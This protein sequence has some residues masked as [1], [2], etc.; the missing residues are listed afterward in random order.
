MGIILE[1]L[2]WR[3]TLPE[4]KERLISL[5]TCGRI[6][7]KIILISLLERISIPQLALGLSFLQNSRTSAGVISL[8]LKEEGLGQPR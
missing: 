8:N 2:S 5:V 7:G 3:G 1:V 4:D 6:R